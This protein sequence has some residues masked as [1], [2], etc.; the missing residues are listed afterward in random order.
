MWKNAVVTMTLDSIDILSCI[1]SRASLT[2]ALPSIFSASASLVTGSI[3]LLR[4][5]RLE[6]ATASFAVRTIYF[7]TPAQSADAI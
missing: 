1:L 5:Y 3:L 2:S 4:H 7:L 6:D